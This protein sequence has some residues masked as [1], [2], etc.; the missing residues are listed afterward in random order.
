M[1]VFTVIACTKAQNKEIIIL[2]L[3]FYIFC[4]YKLQ[5]LNY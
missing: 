1:N 5:Y 3:L 2:K 4:I